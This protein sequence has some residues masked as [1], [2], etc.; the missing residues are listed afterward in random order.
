MQCKNIKK[1]IEAGEY[2]QLKIFIRRNELNT[3]QAGTKMIQ[4]WIQNAKKIKK[5]AKKILRNDI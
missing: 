2:P 5:R 1:D 3:N 4:K